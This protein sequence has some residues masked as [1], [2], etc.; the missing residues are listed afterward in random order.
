MAVRLKALWQ[1]FIEY[2]NPSTVEEKPITSAHI[3][4]RL[5]ERVE[6]Q[7]RERAHRYELA[8]KTITPF[9]AYIREE[10][11]ARNHHLNFYARH[12]SL[13]YSSLVSEQEYA[14]ALLH[15]QDIRYTPYADEMGKSELEN[16][17]TDQELEKK[18]KRT[19]ATILTGI[20]SLPCLVGFFTTTPMSGFVG[21]ALAGAAVYLGVSQMRET[22]SVRSHTFQRYL[23]REIPL[24]YPL[25]LERIPHGL[26][27]LICLTDQVI[28]RGK[29]DIIGENPSELK[30]IATLEASNYLT[31]LHTLRE[32][33]DTLMQEAI[34]EKDNKR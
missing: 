33:F 29:G 28:E 6:I 15:E 30:R 19:M 27:E 10:S 16:F 8:R 7:V 34:T 25:K 4:L 9:G 5:D 14:T 1:V 17:M 22:H 31:F 3:S 18:S 11:F 13:R 32:K 2:E 26:D 21:V 24:S 12:S 23:N 20:T